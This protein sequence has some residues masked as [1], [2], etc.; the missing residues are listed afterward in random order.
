MMAKN[1]RSVTLSSGIIAVA[2]GLAYSSTPATEQRVVVVSGTELQEPL[3]LL[4]E[5]FET[6]HP[7]IDI[8]LSFQ[9]SQEMVNR[10]IDQTDEENPAVLIPANGEL[11]EE[12]DDRW[13]VQQEQPAFY[14]EPRAIAKTQ[15]VAGG[16]AAR[17]GAV[18]PPGGFGLWWV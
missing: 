9:G 3:T 4:T 17:G 8:V 5:R 13:S 14:G 15:L 2:I 6:Q 11:L 12:L 1:V 16:L 18:V 10:Y 7:A